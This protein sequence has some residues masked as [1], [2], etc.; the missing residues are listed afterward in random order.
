MRVRVRIC[1]RDDNFLASKGEILLRMAA[2]AE[3]ET[4][5]ALRKRAIEAYREALVANPNRA[6]LARYL[7]Y[8]AEE[9]PKWEYALQESIEPRILEALKQPLDGN[10]P[11]RIVYRDEINV[12]NEDG[13]K[14]VYSQ[15]AYRVCNDDGREMLQG[16]DAPAYSEQT[17]R[18]VGARVYRADGSTEESRRVEARAE[19]PPLRI[20]DI[21]HVRFRAIRN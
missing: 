7:E 14:S 12:V 16:L 11:Y 21:V 10:D 5:A 9:K 17:A 13:T 2:K 19:F 15:Y 20:G 4:A 18:C 1:P 3:G 8:I 6:D